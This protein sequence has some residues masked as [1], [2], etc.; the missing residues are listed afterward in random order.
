MATSYNKQE[1]DTKFQFGGTMTFAR[2]Q[3]THQ[4]HEMGSD[5]RGLGRWS[6]ISFKGENKALTTI[7]TAYQSLPSNDPL[8]TGSVYNQQKHHQNQ[9]I[10]EKLYQECKLVL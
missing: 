10:F 2:E 6:W 4:V 1:N 7:I 3:I 9:H 8:K 5:E